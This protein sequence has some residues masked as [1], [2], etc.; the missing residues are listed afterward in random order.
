VDISIEYVKMCKQAVE[1]QKQFVPD[2]S[3]FLWDYAPR[4]GYD[5]DKYKFVEYRELI[6]QLVFR[7][8]DDHEWSCVWLPRQDQLQEMVIERGKCS[9]NKD[10]ALS[11]MFHN[12]ITEEDGRSFGFGKA[13]FPDPSM[14]Q[15]WLA[16][17]MKK[18]FKK[19]WN[20][21]NWR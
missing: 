20:G 19:V 2:Q 14:E 15:L 18:N 9:P 8:Y 6:H 1:I 11:Y 4:A 7:T 17:V 13:V 10:V 3:S 21:E 5:Q 16:F 12:W